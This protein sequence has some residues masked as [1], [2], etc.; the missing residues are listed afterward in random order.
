MHYVRRTVSQSGCAAARQTSLSL[1]GT[2]EHWSQQGSAFEHW[3][4]VVSMHSSG[5]QHGSAAQAS[6]PA[7]PQSHC[8]PA[9]VM[10]LPHTTSDQD[11]VGML[12][13]QVATPFGSVSNQE[14]KNSFEH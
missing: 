2:Y 4:P 5:T 9:S 8:S 13:R 14:R 6:E 7:A 11:S 3:L 10:P 1:A 12:A